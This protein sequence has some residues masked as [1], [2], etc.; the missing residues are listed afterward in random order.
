MKV[1]AFSDSHGFHEQYRI[2]EGTDLVICAGDFTNYQAPARNAIEART[3]LKWFDQLPQEYKMVVGGNH[4]T[5]I[6]QQ[7]HNWVNWEE[8]PTVTYLEHEPAS[9]NGIKFFGSP[10]TPTFGTGW[11]W[12]KDRGKLGAYWE[13]IP[14]D[15][16][17]LITHG[18]PKGMLDL[19]FD[20]DGNL[21]FCGDKSLWNKVKEVKP[22][23][24]I[25][26]HIHNMDGVVNAGRRTVHEFN[27][28]F[29]NAS[30]VDDGKFGQG[31]SSFGHIFEI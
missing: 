8:Y 15:T 25:F 19:S 29:I 13:S 11:A 30:S 14:S 18:P 4:D 12:N 23:Y 22:K 17:I 10:W 5:S 26:G 31:L 27:T 9:I 6:W 28:T 21:E 20:K 7:Q 2:P 16:D 3:F 24:H 1:F